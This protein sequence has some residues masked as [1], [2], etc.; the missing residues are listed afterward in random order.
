M[1][2]TK[3]TI[4]LALSAAL[5]Q[6][7]VHA[8]ETA[9]IEVITV[10]SDFRDTSLQAIPSSLTVLAESDIARRHAQN[11]EELIAVAPNVIFQLVRNAL[12]IIKSVVSES[13][14]NSKSQSTLQLVSLSMILI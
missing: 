14:A 3:S 1:K 10:T 9:D 12:V 5:S 13:V 4:A 7:S 2:L 8:D 6:F 11:L